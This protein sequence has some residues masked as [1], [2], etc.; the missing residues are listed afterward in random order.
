LPDVV[1]AMIGPLAALVGKAN[2]ALTLGLDVPIALALKTVIEA[3]GRAG[4]PGIALLIAATGDERTRIRVN[5][6]GGLGRWGKANI[7]ASMACLT[8]VEANDPIPD[9]RTAAKQ[10]SLAVIA[11][12]K[13]AVVD[14]LPKNIPDFEERKLGLSELAE[15]ADAINVDEMVHALSDGRV[16]VRINA[17]RGLAAKGKPAA[18][19]VGNL[20]LACRDSI[21]QVRREAAKALGKL[22]DDAL[23]PRRRPRRSPRWARRPWPRWSAGSRPAASGA[24]G[25]W[26]S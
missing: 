25:G 19:A 14:A 12:E 3:C 13:V 15:Y 9:V 23:S 5:A 21:A 8:A 20:G 6:I 1:E 10:A 4:Q 18:R 16:H 11:R 7:E 22:G 17:A 24:A 2:D 26:V